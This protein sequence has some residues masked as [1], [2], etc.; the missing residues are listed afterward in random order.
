[1]YCELLVAFGRFLWGNERRTG[2]GIDI[3]YR[4]VNTFGM[5]TMRT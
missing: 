5:T 4:S 1:M 2:S 3:K